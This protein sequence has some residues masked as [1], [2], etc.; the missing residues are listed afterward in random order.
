[1]SFALRLYQASSGFKKDP[2][3]MGSKDFM[4][5]QGFK[6]GKGCSLRLPDEIGP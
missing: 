3:I 1:M 2:T 5:P 4:S 6:N